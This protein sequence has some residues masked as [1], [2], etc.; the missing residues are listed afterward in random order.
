MGGT[1]SLIRSVH[2]RLNGVNS[3][4]VGLTHLAE[5]SYIAYAVLIPTNKWDR[6]ELESFQVR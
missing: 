2:I 1:S 3:S 4:S 5:S 6:A